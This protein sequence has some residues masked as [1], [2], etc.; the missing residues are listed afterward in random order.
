MNLHSL[1]RARAESDRP[2][3]VGLIGAGKFGSM[4]LS[5]ALRTESLHMAA[6]VNLAVPDARSA[7]EQVGWPE[8][9]YQA[10][11]MEEAIRSSTTFITEDVLAMLR[12]GGSDCA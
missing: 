4:I 3:R 8:Q 7:C 1:L 12:C 9:A 2:V 6:I 10:T 11:N 5:Q